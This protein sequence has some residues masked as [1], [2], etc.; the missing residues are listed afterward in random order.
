MENDKI[1]IIVPVYN[2]ESHIGSCLDSILKQK[3]NFELIIVNDGSTDSTLAV[4]EDKALNHLNFKIVNIEKNLGV[5]NARNIG[6]ENATG[7]YIMFCDADD[8]Y[9]DNT[10]T[11]ICRTIDTYHPDYIIF[12]RKDILETKETI[13]VYGNHNSVLELNLN[14]EKYI[15][16]YFAKG[17]HTFSVC[18]KAYRK[19]LIY[20]NSIQFH[21]EIPLSEDTLFNLEYLIH[22][23]SFVEDYSIS[24]LRTCRNGS[25][26]YKPIENFY[27]KN[28]E[29]VKLFHNKLIKSTV[30]EDFIDIFEKELYYHY[31]KVSLFRLF[32]NIDGTGFLDRVKKVS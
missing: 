7:N 26:I 17:V 19:E 2:G 30:S 27:F 16:N 1:S 5:S 4:L 3:G 31:G 11:S 29:I 18:N 21:P 6:L 25:T 14:N 22:A 23:K 28:I 32:D 8:K 20:N 15:T 9:S 12:K 13:A 24:Y 10:I